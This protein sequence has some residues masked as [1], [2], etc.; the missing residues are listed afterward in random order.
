MANQIDCTPD[1]INQSFSQRLCLWPCQ[2]GV[3]CSNAVANCDCCG[4]CKIIWCCP[5]SFSKMVDKSS[6]ECRSKVVR[7]FSPFTFVVMVQCRTCCGWCPTEA[8]KGS[9]KN[10]HP[11]PEEIPYTR[12]FQME[13]KK[14]ELAQAQIS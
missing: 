4:L 6:V 13:K 10:P 3:S 14:R 1:L 9:T 8:E 5:V 7:P 11:E 12:V 2:C